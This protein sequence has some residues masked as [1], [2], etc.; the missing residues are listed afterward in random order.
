MS[1]SEIFLIAMVIIFTVPYLVWRLLRTEYYAP[2]VVVQIIGGIL[3]G[4]GVLGAAFPDY[5]KFV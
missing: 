3:L 5:Y 4:P 2:L 1:T